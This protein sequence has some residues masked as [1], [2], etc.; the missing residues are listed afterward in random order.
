MMKVIP[1]LLAVNYLRAFIDSAIVLS[2]FRLLFI[3]V[4]VYMVFFSRRESVQVIYHLLISVLP[5][6]RSNYQKG[7]CW[8]P[9]KRFNPTTIVYLSQ[10]KIR[11][12]YVIWG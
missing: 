11:I 6:R 2:I 1:S 3:A 8:N 10:T 9:I 5:F 4:I 7:E 12:S